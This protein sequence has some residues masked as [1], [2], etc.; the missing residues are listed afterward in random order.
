MRCLAKSSKFSMRTVGR[1]RESAG[2]EFLR[3][4]CVGLCD[5]IINRDRLTDLRP[6]RVS[7][8]TDFPRLSS[9]QARR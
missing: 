6:A 4:S 3:L 5:L 9:P 7:H 1:S 8:A 2:A